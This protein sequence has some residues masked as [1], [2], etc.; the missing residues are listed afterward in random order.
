MHGRYVPVKAEVLQEEE[1]S[2]HADASDIIDWL[3]ALDR[4]PETVFLVHGEPPA[5][6]ALAARIENELGWR[7]VVPDYGEVVTVRPT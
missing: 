6:Q 2:V 1:F 5:A 7:A 4:E 3:R